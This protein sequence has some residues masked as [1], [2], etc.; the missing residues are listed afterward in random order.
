MGTIPF[1]KGGGIST[2]VHILE[3]LLEIVDKNKR[4]PEARPKI[5]MLCGISRHMILESGRKIRKESKEKIFLPFDDKACVIFTKRL[6]GSCL[7]Q[8]ENKLLCVN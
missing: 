4:K 7:R 8:E 6:S 1:R 3:K 5:F 2:H